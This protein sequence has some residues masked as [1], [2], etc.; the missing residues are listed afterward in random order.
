MR[1]GMLEHVSQ[2]WE[3]TLLVDKLNRFQVSEKLLG[4]PPDLC[5]PVDQ[6]PGKLPADDRGELQRLLRRFRQ[7]VNAGHDDVLDRVWDKDLV[8]PLGEN[9]T[10]VIPPSAPTS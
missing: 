4:P 8:Q 5:Q 6:P 2:L 7:T 10:A 3:K 1:E 9:V